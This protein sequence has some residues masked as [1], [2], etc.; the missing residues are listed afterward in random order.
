MQVL[1]DVVKFAQGLGRAKPFSDYVAVLTNPDPGAQTDEELISYVC[2][3]CAAGQYS[4][5]LQVHSRRSGSE[6]LPLCYELTS[7]LTF[8]FVKGGDHLVGT[9]AMADREEGG[10]VDAFLKVYGTANVRVVDAS[11]FPIHIACHTQA[12]V[13]AIAEKVRASS[14]VSV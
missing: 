8:L 13:Y 1:L 12:T 3:F 7:V 5:Y 9:A 11:I 4:R 2:S 14:V 6:S 10:V